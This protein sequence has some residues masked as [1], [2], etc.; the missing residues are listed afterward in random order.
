MDWSALPRAFGLFLATAI[1]ELVGCY[2]P[3]LWLTGKGSVW[4]L[5]PAAFCL[6]SYV[7][8]DGQRARVCHVWRGLYRDGTCVVMGRGRR[9][10]GME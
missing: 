2:L 7:A 9:E 8:P 5:A 3:L 10:A 4:L 6:A 1:A